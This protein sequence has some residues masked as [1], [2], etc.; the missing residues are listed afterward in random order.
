[1]IPTSR[2][3][4]Y[5]RTPNRKLSPVWI[6][7]QKIKYWTRAKIKS[8]DMVI[9][10]M[11]IITADSKY[12]IILYLFW[13]NTPIPSNSSIPGFTTIEQVNPPHRGTKNSTKCISHFPAPKIKNKKFLRNLDTSYYMIY[14]K[15]LVLTLMSFTFFH[16]T[17]TRCCLGWFCIV[18]FKLAINPPFSHIFD[19]FHAVY[20]KLGKQFI[21]DPSYSN[22]KIMLPPLTKKWSL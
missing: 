13:K 10:G 4:T 3:W 18:G 16:S 19:Y 17:Y 2:L 15:F 8:L 9:N 1:M 22:I 7:P 20:I 14:N 11:A 5:I 6:M 12:F 21:D